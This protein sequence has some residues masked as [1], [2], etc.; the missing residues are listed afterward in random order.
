[1]LFLSKPP[2]KIYMDIQYSLMV[3][4]INRGRYR[5]RLKSGWSSIY[6]QSIVE[7]NPAMR[8]I[9]AN[10]IRAINTDHGLFVQN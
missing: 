6:S 7:T 5:N 2:K 8:V 3:E 4:W 1:M 10:K 9:K